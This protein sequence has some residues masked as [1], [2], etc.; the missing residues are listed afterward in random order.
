[1]KLHILLPV[2][3]GQQRSSQSAS[4]QAGCSQD[5]RVVAFLVVNRVFAIDV[6]VGVVACAAL[7]YVGARAA[8][9]HVIPRFAPQL[10]V[11]HA[12]GEVVIVCAAHQ[13]VVSGA[14]VEQV[15]PRFAP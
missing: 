11:T 15:I 5:K 8:V 9:E 7:E 1:M 13:L 14:A 3:V 4:A 10:I 2:G 6:E 12:T